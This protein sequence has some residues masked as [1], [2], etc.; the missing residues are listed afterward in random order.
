LRPCSDKTVVGGPADDAPILYADED[1]ARLLAEVERR[2]GR[3]R[4]HQQRAA[5][6]A[7]CAVVALIAWLSFLQAASGEV[8]AG[9]HPAAVTALTVGRASHSGER[10]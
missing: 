10:S 5:Q 4:R 6:T 2:S 1:V 9:D 7:T 8:R 3:R